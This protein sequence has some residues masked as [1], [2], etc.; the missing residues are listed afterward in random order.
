MQSETRPSIKKLRRWGKAIPRYFTKKLSVN[1]PRGG[2]KP[3]LHP[4]HTFTL[5]GDHCHYTCR[6]AML[7][8]ASALPARELFL[9]PPGFAGSSLTWGVKS[10]IIKGMA[11]RDHLLVEKKQTKFVKHSQYCSTQNHWE[12]P[13]N[14][15][16]FTWTNILFIVTPHP[17][18]PHC[19]DLP[20]GEPAYT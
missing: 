13:Y 4:G 16:C 5:A 6:A 9:V 20:M 8:Q 14:G 2:P 10:Y 1:R 11:K 15:V 3:R 19:L 18:K 17:T 7:P 12:L